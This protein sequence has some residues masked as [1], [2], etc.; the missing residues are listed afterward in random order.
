MSATAR[1]L[2]VLSKALQETADAATE[3][4]YPA[5]GIRM[6]YL[7]ELTLLEFPREPESCGFVS[8]DGAEVVS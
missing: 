1:D 6:E 7:R 8:F 5:T 2:A 4:W 3:R